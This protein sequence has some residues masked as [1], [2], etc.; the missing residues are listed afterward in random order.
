MIVKGPKLVVVLQFWLLVDWYRFEKALIVN[1]EDQRYRD[2]WSLLRYHFEKG[3]INVQDGRPAGVSWVPTLF[4]S[5]AEFT[6]TS[7]SSS[8]SPETVS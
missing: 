1:D 6:T 8:T 7:R 3:H 4:P 5:S 2:G